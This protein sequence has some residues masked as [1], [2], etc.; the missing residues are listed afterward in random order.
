[1]PKLDVKR[2]F[3]NTLF[4]G[5][6]Q[7]DQLLVDPSLECMTSNGCVAFCYTK[8]EK[9]PCEIVKVQIKPSADDIVF[10]IING[11]LLNKYASGECKRYFTNYLGSGMVNVSFKKNNPDVLVPD[12]KVSETSKKRPFCAANFIT[13]AKSLRDHL[14]PVGTSAEECKTY[15]M[16]GQLIKTIM[17][18]GQTH[19]LTHN[20][21]H[22]DN[23]LYDPDKSCF[24]LIDYGRMLFDGSTVDNDVIAKVVTNIRRNSWIGKD[25]SYD[26]MV[27]HALRNHKC[28]MIDLYKINNTWFTRHLFMFDVT[29]IALGIVFDLNNRHAT[30]LEELNRFF[31]LEEYYRIGR[32]DGLM[33]LKKR[34]YCVLHPDN[35]HTLHLQNQFQKLL[36]PGLYWFAIFLKYLSAFDLVQQ[37][38]NGNEKWL[39]VDMTKLERKRIMY[40]F[41]T[42]ISIPKPELFCKFMVEEK[43]SIKRFC[44][45][46]IAQF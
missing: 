39:L 13:G 16:I 15:T 32:K 29:A 8:G 2:Y 31:K 34:E 42:L 41:G 9:T 27:Q 25:R 30:K 5:L 18:M 21:L 43:K 22:T 23:V 12:G 24:V 1:M 35:W 44:L 28:R 40:Q 26:H 20:D 38:Q 46:I 4:V 19:G 6:I 45:D 37:M 33:T 11:V 17:V 14:R 36:C 10:D 7:A 3:P